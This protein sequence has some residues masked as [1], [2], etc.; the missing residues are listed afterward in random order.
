[1]R[2]DQQVDPLLAPPSQKL[3][4]R[5]LVRPSCWPRDVRR[6]D[7]RPHQLG[8]GPLGMRGPASIDHDDASF[9]Q[10]SDGSI[11]LTGTLG[12][13]DPNFASNA[14]YTLSY[15]DLTWAYVDSAGPLG[16]SAVRNGTRTRLGSSDAVTLTSVLTI[17]RSRPNRANATVNWDGGSTFTAA[18]PGTIALGQPAPDGTLTLGG[19]LRWR[20]ST[21]DWRVTV[22][23]PTPL[24]Y[25]KDC[26]ATPRL[27]GGTLT[28]AGT[29]A[30]QSGTL[31]FT[32]S[33]CGIRPVATWIPD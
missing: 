8:L 27:K 20:R 28:L 29:I 22:A 16:Y 32:W 14:G 17:V 26:A 21:E 4:N 12:I 6:R 23:T 11:A 31:G 7:G 33:Q 15:G 10:F 18:V 25:D 5:G 24:V 13:T 2:D 9:W 1:M 3:T 30:G 19:T